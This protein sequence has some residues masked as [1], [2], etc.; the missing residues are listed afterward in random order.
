MRFRRFAALAGSS[1]AYCCRAAHRGRSRECHVA[2]RRPDLPGALEHRWRP[3]GSCWNGNGRT[4]AASP[5]ADSGKPSPR[6]SVFDAEVPD[7]GD[8]V[9]VGITDGGQLHAFVYR[10]DRSWRQPPPGDI[11]DV[12]IQVVHRE[13]QQ[14]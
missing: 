11:A 10:L 8:L 1:G 6:G 4:G 12:L 5:G 13:V 2:D 3:P 9:A 7:E 14:G